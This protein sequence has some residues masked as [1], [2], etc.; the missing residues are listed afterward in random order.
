MATRMS[1]SAM[2]KTAAM[3]TSQ[4]MSMDVSPGR[5]FGNRRAQR[6]AVRTIYVGGAGWWK[7]LGLGN[8]Y[9]GFPIERLLS[10]GGKGELGNGQ[11]FDMGEG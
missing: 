1:L 11:T 6:I 5:S 8:C 3:P 2:S 7:G 4:V 10:T 9:A